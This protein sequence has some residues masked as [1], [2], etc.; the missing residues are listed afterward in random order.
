VNL[1]FAKTD[2]T[3]TASEQMTFT[4]TTEIGGIQKDRTILKVMVFRSTTGTRTRVVSNIVKS[5]LSERMKA[6]MLYLSK[7][8][9]GEATI[10]I[11]TKRRPPYMLTKSPA[12]G[13][14]IN[15]RKMPGEETVTKPC[16]ESGLDEVMPFI[17]D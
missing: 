7:E 5:R 9:V 13:I 1:L 2:L 3:I 4:W 8:T 12:T 14:I 6:P 17:S 15:S 10:L 11:V 16:S